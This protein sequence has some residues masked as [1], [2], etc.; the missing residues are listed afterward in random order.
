MRW[1]ERLVLQWLTR[2]AP[3][4]WSDTVVGDL[5]EDLAAGGQTSRVRMLVA[6]S[7]IGMRFSLESISASARALRGARRQRRHMDS[8][9]D[10]RQAAKGLARTPGFTFVAVLTLALAIGANTAIYS[11]LSSLILNPLPFK[12][13]SRFV[14]LWR[15]N[16]EIGGL[17]VTPAFEVAERWRNAPEIFD[18]VEIYWNDD[19]IMSGL[20]EPESIRLTMLTSPLLDTLGVTPAIGR[21]FVDEDFAPSAEPVVLISHGLWQSRFGG[22][23]SVLGARLTLNE[24]LYTIVGVMPARFTMPLSEDTVWGAARRGVDKPT[25]SVV[26]LARLKAAVSLEEAQSVFGA[27]PAAEENEAEGWKGRLMPVSDLTAQGMKTAISVLSGAVGLLLLIACVNVANLMLTRHGTRER[28]IALRHALGASRVRLMRFLVIESALVAM[29]GGVAGLAVAK[30]AIAAIAAMRP[31]RLDALDRLTLDPQALVFAAAVSIVAALLFGVVPALARSRARLHDLLKSG[32]RTATAHG[33]GVRRILT[34]AQVALALILL[35]GAGLLVRSY[36]RLMAVDLG[37]EPAGVLAVWPSLNEVRY[38]TKEPAARRAFFEQAL[39]SIATVPGVRSVAVG[40]SIPL[41]PAI[42]FGTIEVE[43]R[44]E[45]RRAGIFVGGN[46][47]D[48]YFSALSIKVIEGRTFTANDHGSDVVVLGRS[49]ARASWPDGSPIGRKL[50]IDEGPWLSV[51]GVVDDLKY[52]SI[53]SSQAEPQIYRPLAPD[54]INGGTFIIK[55]DV[56]PRAL[57]PSVKAAIWRVDK[58]MP[59]G[60]IVTAEQV[61][62]RAAGQARFNL[63]LL[64]AFAVCGLALAVVGV[65]GVTSLYVG[66]RQR[67]VGIRMALG[68]SRGSVAALVFRQTTLMI[69]AALAAGAL[70]AW[71][72]SR[73]LESLIFNTATTDTLT[74]A[75]AVVSIALATVVATLVPVRRATSVDPAVVLRA[76]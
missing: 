28:E 14:L 43:G 37:F 58:D 73:Y 35:V 4:D 45:A 40:L 32:G 56:D 1:L 3:D 5:R 71:W 20:G 52:M 75:I 44:P 21:G 34:V 69:T 74:Y 50:R 27:M 64:S 63:L 26:A 57:I 49:Y 30:G 67:E 23:A 8:R 66:Q 12:D 39:A 59:F 31:R 48:D 61:V 25:Y 10:L 46:V 68:A 54:H 22:E 7:G 24:S 72:L 42:S 2:V 29:L 13:S 15:H 16:P 65:Y 18:A 38:P 60:E 47:T 51:I 62:S 41:E 70:G 19:R 17:M 53:A 33:Y 11:A 36:G 55:T 76:D 9:T 6:L